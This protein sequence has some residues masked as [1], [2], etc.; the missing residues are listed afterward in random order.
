MKYEKPEVALIKPAI[1]G[2]QNPEG[3]KTGGSLDGTMVPN[4]QVTVNAYA[5][6]E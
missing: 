6:D 5:A 1:T 2:I 4:F 3:S